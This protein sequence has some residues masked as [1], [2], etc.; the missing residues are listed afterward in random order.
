MSDQTVADEA[1]P[2]ADEARPV[3]DEAQA[4]LKADDPSTPSPSSDRAGVW[5]IIPAYNEGTMIG[6]VVGELLSEGWQVAVIDDGS[7]D[8]TTAV[9]NGAGAVVITH[10]TNRGQGAALQTGFDFARAE[11]A[12]VV[13]TLDADGQHCASDVP[14][15][16]DALDKE[17]VD[18]ILGSRFLGKV[19]GAGI[20]R[21]IFL[22]LATGLSNRLAGLRL[23][24]AHCGIR[25]IR[26]TV[27]KDLKITS[28]GMAHASQILVAIAEQNLSWREVPVTVRY[29]SYSRGKGQSAANAL[30][31]LIDYFFHRSRGGQ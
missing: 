12:R 28:D 9:A 7:S 18:I 22:R 6:Q 30:Q 31:I 13:V 11:K 24:D 2:V 4:G 21:R 16:V 14:V 19:E 3:A 17:G 20:G 15:L 29:S 5:I 27:L 1:R 8:D 23:T 26:A 10:A 25:A